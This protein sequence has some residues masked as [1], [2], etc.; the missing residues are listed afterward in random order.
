MEV[1][2]VE[3]GKD[4]ARLGLAGRRRSARD[5]DTAC[6]R[7]PGER[8]ENPSRSEVRRGAFNAT[9]GSARKE[10]STRGERGS[11]GEMG[12]CEAPRG[13]HAPPWRP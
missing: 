1:R 7:A 12:S 4:G 13:S 6:K 9:P 11:L 10:A 3:L 2:A 5:G 8:Q